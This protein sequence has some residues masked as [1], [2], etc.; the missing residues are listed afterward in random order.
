MVDIES[1]GYDDSPH[2]SGSGGSGLKLV[3]PSLKTVQAL[4]GKKRKG[5]SAVHEEPPKKIPRPPKLKPLKEVLTRLI[6]QIKK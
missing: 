4:K 2:A 1:T 3:L 5:S 6:V